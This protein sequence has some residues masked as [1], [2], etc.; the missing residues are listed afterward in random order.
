MTIRFGLIGLG[1][2]GISHLA[3]VNT[4]PDVELAAVC[5][6]NRYVL[7]VLNKYTGVRGY[8]DHR[9]MI[10]E[11]PLDAAIISTPSRIHGELVRYALEQNVHVFCEKPFCLDVVEGA[12]LVDLAEEKG[13]VNQVG[14]HYRF[15]SA[16]NEAKRLIDAGVIGRVHHVRVE[17]YGPV[18]LRTKG[19]TWR[20]ARNE[21]GG[22]LYDY[23]C[24]AIDL[25][26]YLMGAPNAV[27]GT[28][29][30]KI[31][32][33][34]VEDEVYTTLFFPDGKTAQIAANWC[35]ESHR[36][37]HTKVTI[38]GTNGRIS[39]DRQECQLY[40]REPVEAHPELNRGWSARF[41]TDL[42]EPVWFY[43]RGE[44]YSAQ[45]DYFIRCIRD[46]IKENINSFSSARQTDW[47][48]KMM[49]LDAEAPRR[50]LDAEGAQRS[51][52]Q[53][54]KGLF[55]RFAR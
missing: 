1:K 49:Q 6:S 45:I 11:V 28:V 36:K 38:W 27:G 29:L 54:P 50:I 46:G 8:T 5:D 14:Y 37:M 21:G 53:Q 30:N 47:V 12:A 16:F 33:R 41:T 55:A 42:T 3:T 17:A 32:S 10:Q 19:A 35:D 39:A 40:L 48:V 25:A 7:D 26:I 24:H 2:M 34:E 43:L 22:C 15:V 23:A 4:H 44:E 51:A 52:R 13:L 31:F 20:T 9:K 18:I